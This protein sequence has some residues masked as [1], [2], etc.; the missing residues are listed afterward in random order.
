MLSWYIGV[1]TVRNVAHKFW[2]ARTT[3]FQFHRLKQTLSSPLAC[4]RLSVTLP[5]EHKTGK[6]SLSS[7][8]LKLLFLSCYKY[9]QLTDK[10]E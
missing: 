1:C 5:A 3:Q 9:I 8:K 7:T 10:I 4:D 2:I 6:W